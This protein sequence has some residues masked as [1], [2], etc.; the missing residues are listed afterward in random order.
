MAVKPGPQEDRQN[1]GG[2]ATN[3]PIYEGL[4]KK[5]IKRYR[6]EVAASMSSIMSTFVAF[7]L[8]SVKTR[9]QTYNHGSF[10][11]CVRYTYKTEGYRGFLRGV[12][13]PMAS[14]TLVRTISFSMYQRSKY[15]YSKWINQNFGF[16]P[17]VHVNTP[18]NY[19]NLY[20]VSCF[21][22]AGATAGSVITL[23]ACPF[24]L[25]K[26]SAQVS[27]LMADR[28]VSSLSEPSTGRAVAASYQNKGTWK[29]AKNIVKHRGFAGLYSGLKLHLMRDT[30]G[31]AIYF[32]TYESCKQ[33]LTTYRGDKS[34]T[35][36][37]AVVLAG[38]LCGV[39]SWALIYPIDSAKSI[40]Q[41][42][43]LTY[44]KGETVKEAPKIQFF[45][46]RMYRGLGVSMGRSCVVN[47]IFFSAFEFIKK[48]INSVED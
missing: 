12:M 4:Q 44:C 37:T 43:C 2:S 6:T 36:A 38:G 35:N 45:N 21:G 7:P 11:D 13:A 41:R 29:T 19:P 28:K 30:L 16:D 5:W 26:L 42:N 18:G 15:T 20:T 9:M 1:D 24:E 8:D 40:Y 23:V 34:P 27:V 48:Q 22:A 39:T 47:S 33:L 3:Q 10:I 46:K 14:V 17:L 31:T 32:M 25:T